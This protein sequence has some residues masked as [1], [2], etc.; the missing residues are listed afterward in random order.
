[1]VLADIGYGEIEPFRD[2]FPDRYYNVGV[3]GTMV[4]EKMGTHGKEGFH[5]QEVGTYNFE[6][7]STHILSVHDTSGYYARCKAFFVTDNLNEAPT[8]DLETLAKFYTYSAS[9]TQTM[10]DS[11]FPYWATQPMQEQEV[12]TLEN[13]TF[14]VNFIQGVGSKGNLVQNEIFVK[15]DT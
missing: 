9:V 1:M 15:K 7:N 12:I 11:Q 2:T 14:K 5:W 10:P 3:D 13:D 6:A 4:P 8:D